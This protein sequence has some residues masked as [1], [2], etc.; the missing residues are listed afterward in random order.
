MEDSMEESSISCSEKDSIYSRYRNL[1]DNVGEEECDPD[2]KE[3]VAIEEALVEADSL[4][5]KVDNTRLCVLDAQLIEKV[6]DFCVRNARSVNT[7]LQSFEPNEFASKI[8]SFV[9]AGPP[10]SEDRRYNIKANNWIKL[11]KGTQLLFPRVPYLTYLNGAIDKH[12]VQEVT[13]KKQR[14][15]RNAN[16]DAVVATRS[17]LLKESDQASKDSSNQTEVLV[18]STFR[19]LV[20]EFRKSER[21]P[22]NYFIF[23]LDPTSYSK[24]IENIFHLSFL[25]HEGKVAIIMDE[26]ESPFPHIH[27]VKQKKAD[28]DSEYQDEEKPPKFQ[29][30]ISIQKKEWNELV[31]FLQLESPVIDHNA[32]LGNDGDDNGR[33][34]RKN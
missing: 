24:T 12:G 21:R 26:D 25:V 11:G 5:A 22:I 10:S 14:S 27:P 1:L 3:D 29:S 30:V 13:V 33:K 31:S 28:K 8:A 9:K 19:Q 15:Q 4:F 20:R 18:E 16:T 7:N 34:R 17:T 23:V 2:E 32:F 6:S